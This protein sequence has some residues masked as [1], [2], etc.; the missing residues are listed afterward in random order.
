MTAQEAAALEGT[1]A[2]Y[3]AE[4]AKPS[5]VNAAD[6]NCV[7]FQFGCGYNNFWIDR[8]SK[9]VTINGEKRTSLLI[10]PPNGKV[11]DLTERRRKEIAAQRAGRGPSD[12]P[13]T[14][15]L[16]DRC[17]LAFGSSSGPPMLPVLYNNHYQIVQ[18]KDHVVILV[19]MVHDARI[20]RLG[21][22]HL[23]ASVPK[24]MGDSVGRW[25]GDTLVVETTN[26]NAQQSFRGSTP[27]MKVT[28]RFT[29]TGPGS[30]LYRFTVE[31]PAAF[32][33]PFTGEVPVY[34]TSDTIYEYACHEG[35]YA[36]PGI[37]GGAREAEKN[38]TAPPPAPAV[39]ED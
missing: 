7:K 15:T 36:M 18:N 20:I 33:R 3:V 27:S 19:E 12:G 28:E 17:L 31:D 39:D 14:R 11:P 38:G 5:D 8:G 4:R 35:N 32:T 9:V 26:F 13:E 30:L 6:P 2:K 37:L 10:D 29:P 22:K 21:G 34:S 16:S 24:W 25:E 23:P 1:E